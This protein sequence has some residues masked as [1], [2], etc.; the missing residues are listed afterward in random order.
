LSKPETSRGQRKKTNPA[1]NGQKAEGKVTF[2]GL[3]KRGKRREQREKIAKKADCRIQKAEESQRDS[4]MWKIPP[5]ITTK[6]T[7]YE[8]C[9]LEAGVSPTYISF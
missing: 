6:A 2:K 8:K 4:K 9:G 1:S 3:Q 5:P 7:S